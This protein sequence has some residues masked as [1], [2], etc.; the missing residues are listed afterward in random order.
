MTSRSRNKFIIGKA[1]LAESASEG[2]AAGNRVELSPGELVLKFGPRRDVEILVHLEPSIG[3]SN[4]YA[5]DGLGNVVSARCRIADGSHGPR[6]TTV[7]L[8]REASSGEK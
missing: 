5:V 6:F 8:T 1:K 3:I 4:T 2:G 7:S